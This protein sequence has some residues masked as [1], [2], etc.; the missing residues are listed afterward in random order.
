MNLILS[1]LITTH[2]LGINPTEFREEFIPIASPTNH[3]EALIGTLSVSETGPHTATLPIQQQ[4]HVPEEIA[5]KIQKLLP[6]ILTRQKDE[7]LE[8]LSPG[9]NLI[10]KLKG[11]PQYVFKSEPPYCFP[12]E[13]K[14]PTGDNIGTHRRFKNMIKAQEV[15]TANGLDLLVM[16]RATELTVTADGNDYMFI[17]EES[18]NVESNESA[19]EHYYHVYST[20]LNE[21]VR[22]LAIFIANTGFNDV[23]WRNIPVLKETQDFQ[24]ARRIAL[25]DLEHMKSV[26]D[27]FIGDS[28]GS[29][30]LIRCVAEEQIDMV[31]AEAL[32]QR[33][34]LSEQ[35]VQNA[36]KRRLEE[37]KENEALRSFYE[38]KGIITGKEPL[39]V[40]LDSLG[41]KLT[42]EALVRVRIK[43]EEGKAIREE[44]PVTLR[45][46]AEDVI[47]E[48]N[49]L[50]QNS[51]DQ[52]STKGKR[53]LV[54]N[55]NAYPFRS[56]MS[57]GLPS[58][59][60]ISEEEEKQAW[61]RRIV[62]ALVK[63]GYLFKLDQVNGHGYFIQA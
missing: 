49:Q 18:L 32:Y 60:V 56:Y 40:D 52:A 9:G 44:Q 58:V 41:L 22:Q 50:I 30:G 2:V 3:P 38:K 36:K 26:V 53:Y 14:L 42:E 10:F 37:L 33:V 7:A 27:G 59:I 5:L 61:L 20:E 45:K 43:T 48:I 17:V 28:Y 21:A 24:G 63:K 39:Q 12:G 29:R 25:I 47:A 1:I 55:T 15:C 6:K 46:V 13:G 31:I 16:P 57:L 54:L 19:H 23:S 35:D 51:S 62:D 4:I 11:H 34:P 8:W